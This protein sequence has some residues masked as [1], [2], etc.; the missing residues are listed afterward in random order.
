MLIINAPCWQCEKDML[1]ALEGDEAGN[2]A[3]GPEAF[4]DEEQKKATENGVIL[5]EVESQTAGESYLANVCGGCGAFIGQWYF[6][7]HYYT[8]ALYG[9]YTY[10]NV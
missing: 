6:F 10:K 5:K 2:L 3:Y 8:P 1:I 7:A 9:Q 4:S